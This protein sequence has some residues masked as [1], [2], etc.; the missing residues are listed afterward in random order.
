[1]R[2][3]W[4]IQAVSDLE[5]LHRYHREGEPAGGSCGCGP[6]TR[7]SGATGYASRLG[8]ART[9]TRDA[10]VDRSGG[11]PCIVPYRMRD[12]GIEVLR[13]MHMARKWPKRF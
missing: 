8:T 2:I 9:C 1:V 7:C 10:R 6:N 5:H 11:T 12:E 3:R 13:V 4:F